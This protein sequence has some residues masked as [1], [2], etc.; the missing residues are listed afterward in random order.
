MQNSSQ[1][2]SCKEDQ[3]CLSPEFLDKALALSRRAR[4]QWKSPESLKS[5]T[6]VVT[7][8]TRQSHTRL[9]LSRV[10]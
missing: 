8:V 3:S 9:P 5:S 1:A 2:T 10:K 6:L 4:R 7:V